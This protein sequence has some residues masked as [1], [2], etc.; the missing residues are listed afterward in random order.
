MMRVVIAYL[1]F[2]GSASVMHSN[3]LRTVMRLL[4][5]ECESNHPAR[6]IRDGA[7]ARQVHFDQEGYLAIADATGSE[8]VRRREL[9]ETVRLQLGYRGLG[10]IIAMI[11]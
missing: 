7:H 10:P 4:D 6:N 5:D 11:A 1:Q 9:R 3:D 2:D 8:V